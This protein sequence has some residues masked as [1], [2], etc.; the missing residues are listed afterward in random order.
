MRYLI[1]CIAFFAAAL[2]GVAAQPALKP[3][4]NKF[5]FTGE[6]LKTSEVDQP[7]KAYKLIG[8]RYPQVWSQARVNGEAQVAFIINAKGYTEQVQV[9]S[10]NDEEFG[11]AARAAVA[12][13]RFKAGR[14]NGKPVAVAVVQKVEFNLEN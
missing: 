1:A 12:K 11:A 6:F 3:V 14:K 13:W 5:T 7:P 4:Q 2:T 10:A 8:P 9:V